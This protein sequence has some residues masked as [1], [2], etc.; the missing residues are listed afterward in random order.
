YPFSFYGYL[1]REQLIEAG[2]AP[3]SLDAGAQMRIV[4][5]FIDP[6]WQ[7]SAGARLARLGLY[8][9]AA[10]LEQARLAGRETA[11]TDADRWRLGALEHLAGRFAVSHNI[12]R[13]NIHGRPWAAPPAGRLV[14]WR[15]AWPNP[16]ERDILR[17]IVAE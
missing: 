2:V 4:D 11:L 10:D 8:Q 14:R 13:R 5:W 16:F 1:A 9:M 15:I 12:A 6:E 3:E 17:A 7:R